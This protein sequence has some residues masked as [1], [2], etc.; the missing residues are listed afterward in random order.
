MKINIVGAG[1]VGQTLGKL[2]VNTKVFQVGSIYNRTKLSAERAASFIGTGTP[3]AN[4][5]DMEQ[6]D[7]YMITTADGALGEVCDR[8]LDVHDFKQNS[9]IFHCSGAVPSRIFQ[10]AQEHGCYIASVHPVKS[11]A[12]PSIAVSDFKGTFCAVE[13]DE[14]ALGIL[15]GCFQSIGGHIFRINTDKKALYHGATVMACN[16]LVALIEAATSM[17]VD[18]GLDRKTAL[19]V[20]EPIVRGTITNIFA[21][22]AV[23]AL[24]GPIA[25]GDSETV[26]THLNALKDDDGMLTDVYCSLGKWAL[27]LSKEQ[28]SA[29]SESLRNILDQLNIHDPN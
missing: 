10:R 2:L 16:N 11:F 25:R 4:L 19:K 20:M 29:T 23:S 28:G 8:M 18:S 1:R 15:E 6:A 24:T 27:N 13:G 7:L 12:E 9:V 22:G 26:S 5:S 14:K 3:I 21:L 17:Y